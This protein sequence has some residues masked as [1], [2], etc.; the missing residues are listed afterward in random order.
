M[1]ARAVRLTAWWRDRDDGDDL[2][3]AAL[4]KHTVPVRLGLENAFKN[5]TGNDRLLAAVPCW[6]WKT[7]TM[8][9]WKA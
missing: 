1:L 4:G 9:R 6:P 7:S 3:A 5:T 2:F 8:Q